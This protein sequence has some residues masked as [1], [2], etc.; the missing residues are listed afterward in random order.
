MNELTKI[1]NSRL[2]ER[3]NFHWIGNITRLPGRTSAQNGT[4]S[5][6]LQKVKVIGA[7]EEEGECLVICLHYHSSK[8]QTDGRLLKESA[9]L[10]V[11]GVNMTITAELSTT[12]LILIQRRIS[13]VANKGHLPRMKSPPLRAL[14]SKFQ[15]RD[16]LSAIYLLSPVLTPNLFNVFFHIFYFHLLITWKKY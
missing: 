4:V 5:L 10:S 15:T 14:E 9:S 7:E 8:L 2:K 1:E 11:F 12:H 16:L 6:S 13:P 3:L